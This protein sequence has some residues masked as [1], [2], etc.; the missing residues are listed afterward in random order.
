MRVG[1]GGGWGLWVGWGGVGRVWCGAVRECVGGGARGAVVWCGAGVE[2]GGV[3]GAV[4]WCG[5][6]RDWVG[7]WVGGSQ[8]ACGVHVNQQVSSPSEAQP[9]SSQGGT[10]II[11]PGGHRHHPARGAQPSS[12][13]RGMYHLHIL[14]LIFLLPLSSSYYYPCCCCCR[15]CYCPCLYSCP[16]YW[17][18]PA[19]LLILLLPLRL[20][21]L[22]LTPGA[23]PCA[24]RR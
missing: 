10:A 14:M 20:L 16:C 3:R 21:P 4:V 23:P 18:L 2:G 12:S 5:V 19:L 11:Q 15:S 6:V 9:S 24:A 7:G 13:Q 8:G 22:P 1:K 17:P